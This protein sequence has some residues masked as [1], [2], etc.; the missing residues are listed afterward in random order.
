M[1]AA[2]NTRLL[3]VGN[4]LP[5]HVGAHLLRA[6]HAMDL[7]ARIV[8]VREAFAVPRLVQALYWRCFGRRP[9]RLRS[10]GR[11]VIAMCCMYRPH[12]LLATGLAPLDWQALEEIGDRGIKRLN[13]VTDDPWNSAHRSS[14]F[15]KAL[16]CYDHVFSPRRANLEDLRRTGSTS[17]TYL[18]FAY[19]PWVHFRE[20]PAPA[21]LQQYV[22]DL[23]F[24]GGADADRVPI[25]TRLIDAGF[26]VALYGGYWEHYRET[27]AYTHGHADLSTLRKAVSTAQV[28]LCLVRRANRDGH[29]MRTFEVPAM[30]GCMIAEDTEEH[31]Q[32]LGEDGDAVVYFESAEEIVAK[33]HQLLADDRWR[34][35]LARRAHR[36]VT[37]GDHTYGHR[38]STM[39]A[40][41]Q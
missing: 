22:C 23:V 13:F 41:V 36:R 10:F 15:L 40:R 28:N 1:V 39:L 8:D 16:P 6:A 34:R 33:L 18:P 17:V 4:P 32:I 29:V 35:R 9:A 24:A 3:V 26:D 21:E 20:A 25:V 30:G 37:Q 12:L 38:L 27:R 14:W 5:F 31:H 2:S 11:R 19:D 7:D